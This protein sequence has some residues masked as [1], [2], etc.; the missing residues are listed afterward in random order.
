MPFDTVLA[1]GLPKDGYFM[2]M[3]HDNRWNFVHELIQEPIS[4][5]WY[6]AARPFSHGYA[7]V[8]NEKD[9]WNYVDNN[10]EELSSKWFD[11]VKDFFGGYGAVRRKK[12][13]S[14]VNEDGE[15][16][17]KYDTATSFSH[18]FASVSIKGR[19]YFINTRFEQVMGPFYYASNVLDAGTAIVRDSDGQR[20]VL[21]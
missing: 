5:T 20:S 21:L 12:L 17:G 2:V 19:Y 14:Y 10:G 7:A 18:G 1:V 16:H 4:E 11:E 13:W 3:R 9:K 15:I 6:Y 8:M